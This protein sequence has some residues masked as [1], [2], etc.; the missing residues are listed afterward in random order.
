MNTSI[1]V[2]TRTDYPR[3][4]EIW[5][6]AVRATHHFLSAEDFEYYK[7][8]ITTYFEHV[9]LYL[10][11]DPSGAVTGFIG[12]SPDSVEMLFVDNAFRGQGIGKALLAFAIE[13]LGVCKVDVNEQNTQA[14]GF[15]TRM[16]FRIT[17][18]SP[19]D[20]E[21]KAYPLLHM[22]VRG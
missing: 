5:E 14:I 11:K 8:R 6:S 12:V 2:A 18:R 4:A 17:G 20:S 19:L 21:G 15:Y 13:Q 22:Q 16:G 3:M 9:A 7:A 1:T 10:Y